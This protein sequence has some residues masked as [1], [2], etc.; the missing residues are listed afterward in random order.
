MSKKTTMATQPKP[1]PDP[2]PLA[3]PKNVK[4]KKWFRHSLALAALLVLLAT[5]CFWAIVSA[6]LQ[7]NNADQLVDSYMLENAHTMHGASFPGQ[8]TFLLKWPIFWLQ[9]VFGYSQGSFII[10]TTLVV[11]VTVGGLVYILWRIERRPL[12]FGLL[13]LALA[14]T[15]LVVPPVPYPGALLPVNMAMLTTRNLE[16]LLYI[17][18]LVMVAR[19]RRIRTWRFAIATLC[20]AILFASD[21]LFGT[22]SLGG[23]IVMLVLYTSA[24][25]NELRRLAWRWFIATIVGLALA[26]ALLSLLNSTG[27]VHIVGQSTTTPY[28][29]VPSVR[30]FVLGFIYLF[31][32][33]ATNLGANP[34]ASATTLAAVPHAVRDEVF[35]FS[36]LSYVVNLCLLLIGVGAC[37]HVLTRSFKPAKAKHRKKLHPLGSGQ[38]LSLMLIG[39]TIVAGVSFVATNH[40]YVADSRYLAIALFAVFVSLASYCQTKSLRPKTVAIFSLLLI[41]AICSGSYKV[42]H[43]DTKNTQ[44]LRTQ[45]DRTSLIATALASH[46]TDVVVGD[47]WRVLPLKLATKGK[48]MVLPLASCTTPRDILTSSAWQPDLRHHSFTYILSLDSTTKEFGDCSLNQIVKVY[49][50]PSASTIIAGTND[51]PREIMLFYDKGIHPIKKPVATTQVITGS[52]ILHPIAISN[53]KHTTCPGHKTIMQIVAH[54]DDDLLFMSPDLEHAIQAGDCVRTVYV[55]AGDAGVGKFYWLAREQGSQAAYSVLTHDQSLWQQQ[56]AKL[57]DHQFATI[58]MPVKNTHVS[59]IYLH[60]PDGSPAGQGFSASNFES[61]GKLENQS[62]STVY[63]V[64]HQSFYSSQ[65]LAAALTSLMNA[66]RPDEVRTQLPFSANMVYQD[67][68]DHNAVGGFTTSAYQSYLA[69]H[70]ETSIA[71]YVGYPIHA[72]APNVADSDLDLKQRVFFAYSSF[73]GAA[74]V[75]V[76][77]CDRGGVYGAYLNREYRVDDLNN[78]DLP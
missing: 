41:L 3:V 68:S 67:H 76:T 21:K 24:R 66:Y 75:S 15:L 22:L 51:K 18:G 77:S 11:L 29:L 25:Q 5:T 78:P 48:Q 13:C 60:L 64:D 47:Y 34:A 14:S 17:L 38:Q 53:L 57:G 19:T 1:A 54:E 44:A 39:S 20:F 26:S 37:L 70:P 27:M 65:T 6:R 42:L 8:H 58:D 72:Y 7:N 32:A 36:G 69:I 50:K 23:S 55:T 56:T 30:E 35:S 71:Y 16:Y 73:D 40:Y 59:L 9:H 4:V 12:R 63:S 33:L 61:L 49:G 46:H 2:Q 52:S 74:C 28:G 10:L 31:F 45:Q 62:I 43:T